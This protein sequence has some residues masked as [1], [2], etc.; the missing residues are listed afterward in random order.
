MSECTDEHD[1]YT[2]WGLLERE[3]SVACSKLGRAVAVFARIKAK[4]YALLALG[5]DEADMLVLCKLYEDSDLKF[6]HRP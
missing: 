1:E 2:S 3:W 5:G 6:C 4:A